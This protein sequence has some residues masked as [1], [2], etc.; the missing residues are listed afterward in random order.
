[1]APFDARL[2]YTVNVVNNV[3]L[4]NHTDFVIHPHRYITR[5]HAQ[6]TLLRERPGRAHILENV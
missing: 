4:Q 2:V 5:A 3:N 1:M 6:S